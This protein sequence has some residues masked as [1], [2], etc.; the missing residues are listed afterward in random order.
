MHATAPDDARVPGDAERPVPRRRVTIRDVA[1]ASFTSVATVSVALSGG[2][3]VAAETR[4][5]VQEVADRLGWRPN[6]YASNLRKT[7]SRLIGFVCEVEQ[8]FQMGL[9]DSLYVA[10][11]RKGLE[12]V[13]AGATAHHDERTCVDESLR[14]RCQAIILTGSGLTEAEMSELAGAVP[15]VSL[16]GWCMRPA[17]TWWSPTTGWGWGRPSTTSRSWA[18]GASTTPTVGRPIRWRQA[19]RTPTCRPWTPVGSA[20]MHG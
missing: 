13:L 18:T 6:R 9:V 4:A 15:L 8:V 16:C 12:L 20:T 3:G 2:A 11:Q 5:H 19:A 10:A 17:S 7:D 14:A 1:R